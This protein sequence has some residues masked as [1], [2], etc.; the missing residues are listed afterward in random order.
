MNKFSNAS[1]RAELSEKLGFQYLVM[2][3]SDALP[4]EGFDDEFD[5]QKHITS[6]RL[7]DENETGGLFGVRF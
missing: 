3:N 5:L 2:M 6:V 1:I 7:T 4:T